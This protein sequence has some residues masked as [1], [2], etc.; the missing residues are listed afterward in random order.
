MKKSKMKKVLNAVI[1]AVFVVTLA[2][3]SFSFVACGE[4][5]ETEFLMTYELAKQ[6]N[7]EKFGVEEAA[8]S[9]SDYSGL[10]WFED[11]FIRMADPEM[12]DPNDRANY[13]NIV[14]NIK[15][16]KP[17]L[18][19]FGN[20]IEGSEREYNIYGMFQ[21]P[22]NFRPE[23]LDE[24]GGREFPLAIECHGFN[25]NSNGFLSAH[26]A[27]TWTEKGYI[28]YAFDFVGG[29]PGGK[30]NYSRGVRS[31]P[32][33]LEADELGTPVDQQGNPTSRPSE[34]PAVDNL[35]D[36][37]GG[38][39]LDMSVATEV[40]DLHC[41]IDEVKKLDIVDESNICIMGQSQG[42]VVAAIVAAERQEIA[43][44]EDEDCDVAG[45]VLIYPAFSFITDMHNFFDGR[46][47]GQAPET[48]DEESYQTLLGLLDEDGRTFIMG[49]NVGPKY[50]SQ[51]YNYGQKQENGEY[52]MYHMVA[53]YR[54]SVLIVT[55]ST[56][57]TVDTKWSFNAIYG[58]NSA[59]GKT[60]SQSTLV[61]VSDAEHAFDMMGSTPVK[62]KMM[63]YDALGNY[64]E[65]NGLAVEPE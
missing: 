10:K 62:Q 33:E 16:T 39:W 9:G 55:G 36:D 2:F 64:L 35:W 13:Y 37:Y 40:Q 11:G 17:D 65:R 42:A 30:Y 58:N 15:I 27:N 52:T 4:S 31:G 21:V 43:D 50:I 46:T 41:V 45:M 7:L 1:A 5:E 29:A 63:A 20:V 19:T 8:I 18:D 47:N 38:S 25:T 60:N 44:D 54:G 56:D 12:E 6:L 3:A 34:V 51:C 28:C 24:P 22:L 61:L 59:Y 53:G 23:W 48:L 49:A 32:V 57:T 26:W 14:K